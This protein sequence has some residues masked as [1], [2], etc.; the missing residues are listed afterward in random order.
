[1]P[2][3]SH[4]RGKSCLSTSAKFDLDFSCTKNCMLSVK[5][6]S[7]EWFQFFGAKFKIKKRQSPGE[8]PSANAIS[9]LHQWVIA[10]AKLKSGPLTAK[11][12]IEIDIFSIGIERLAVN[13]PDYG[14]DSKMAVLSS[15]VAYIL[16]HKRIFN[17]GCQT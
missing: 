14:N 1:M 7:R 16:S 10:S 9:I 13:E 12:S 17:C 5:S 2:L 11:R 8:S 6:I 15:K 3:I 4:L